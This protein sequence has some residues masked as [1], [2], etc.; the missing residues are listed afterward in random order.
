MGNVSVK[1]K[2]FRNLLFYHFF[3]GAYL[4]AN[5]VSDKNRMQKGNFERENIYFFKL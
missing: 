4:L 1:W 3:F 2:R 5:I